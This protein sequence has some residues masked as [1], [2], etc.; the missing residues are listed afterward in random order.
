MWNQLQLRTLLQR[1]TNRAGVQQ[2]QDV[3]KE[4]YM[5]EA[6]AGIFL[7]LYETKASVWITGY[8]I[9]A[10]YKSAPSSQGDRHYDTGG[11]WNSTKLSVMIKV[12]NDFCVILHSLSSHCSPSCQN[13]WPAFPRSTKMPQ[14]FN[15]KAVWTGATLLTACEKLSLENVWVYVVDL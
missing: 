11:W 5:Q 6:S 8:F 15:N 14:C 1:W 3:C 2:R 10:K 9:K 7:L 12:S 4:M 13:K